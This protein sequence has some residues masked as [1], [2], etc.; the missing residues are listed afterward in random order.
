[1]NKL[2]IILDD[3]NTKNIKSGYFISKRGHAIPFDNM[4][5]NLSR[6]CNYCGEEKYYYDFNHSQWTNKRNGLRCKDCDRE[7]NA[8]YKRDVRLNNKNNYDKDMAMNLISLLYSQLKF[9]EGRINRHVIEEK[10]GKEKY[11]K[12][13]RQAYKD[14]IIFGKNGYGIKD[15]IKAKEIISNVSSEY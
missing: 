15:I 6:F 14:I 7:Y 1:M 4:Q 11:L 13:I 5:N 12:P 9:G 3:I 8:T 2:K 10:I